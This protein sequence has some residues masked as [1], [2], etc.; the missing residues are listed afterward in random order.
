MVHGDLGR[1]GVRV[2][3]AVSL[4]LAGLVLATPGLAAG[5]GWRRPDLTPVTQPV[6]VAGAFVLYDGSAGRLHVVALDARTGK[7]R[8][9]LLASISQVTPGEA[10]SLY[11][12]GS[13]VIAL[14][15]SSAE[16]GVAVVAAIDARTGAT[17]WMSAPGR[18]SSTPAPCPGEPKVVC[19]SG[20]LENGRASGDLRFD[21]ATGKTLAPAPIAGQGAREISEGLIDPGLR[22]PE[23]LVATRGSA[24]AWRNTLARI[25]GA[26]SSTDSG[27]DIERFERLGLFVGSVGYRP[28]KL[29]AT[30]GIFDMSRQMSA[31]FRI[32]NGAVVWRN[33]GALFV[34]GLLPCPG[35]PLGVRAAQDHDSGS[36]TV[37]GVR[38]RMAG[39]AK[40]TFAGH[41]SLSPGATATI[42]GFDP[43][44]GRTIWRFEAGHAVG[45]LTQTFHAAQ[46][47]VERLVLRDQG[48]SYVDLDLRTGVRH[49][50]DRTARGWC[51]GEIVYHQ[52]IPYDTSHGPVTKYVG[53]GSLF[54]CV[55]TGA[56]LP[57]PPRAGA[58]AAAIGA[59]ANGI[60]AWSDTGGVIAVPAT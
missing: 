3:S 31:G 34:C 37:V 26:G 15:G 8:W 42:E 36:K 55:A 39:T 14:L 32:A 45:L 29:T 53:Q 4:C 58:V 17:A 19:A 20:S 47:G 56:R 46:T 21:L 35:L 52:A 10:P 57:T 18:F 25:F 40:A 54:P 50:V 22:T 44:T 12:A 43:A 27:W 59:K 28:R 24:I 1:W 23:S 9:S 41:V 33:R 38:L 11:P 51:R 30:Y 13:R 7:T 16:P 49:R 48:G 60:V 2:A 5:R 6:A